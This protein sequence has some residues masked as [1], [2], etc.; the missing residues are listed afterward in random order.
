MAYEVPKK[1][2]SQVHLWELRQLW[3]NAAKEVMDQFLADGKVA[4]EPGTWQKER[5]TSY[6]IKKKL[7]RMVTV[8][9]GQ[10]T[11]VALEGPPFD[12]F[13]ELA[14]QKAVL[15]NAIPQE[16]GDGYERMLEQKSLIGEDG[17]ELESH[18][19][20]EE[21]MNPDV[22]EK[23]N[24]KSFK[25]Y[26]FAL[27]AAIHAYFP[28]ESWAK[29]MELLKN[30]YVT[31]LHEKRRW[32][33]MTKT[34]AAPAPGGRTY[35]VEITPIN[36][37]YHAKFQQ[38]GARGFSSMGPRLTVDMPEKH[39]QERATN[40]WH[41]RFVEDGPG[42]ETLIEFFRSGTIS[43]PF[44]DLP[45][46][47]RKVLA[48]AKAKEVLTAILIRHLAVHGRGGEAPIPIDFVGVNLQTGVK[49]QKLKEKMPF[50]IGTF[51][52]SAAERQSIREHMAAL[53]TFHDKDTDFDIAGDTVTAH[54]RIVAFNFGVNAAI[55][56]KKLPK[57][58]PLG[59]EQD[60]TNANALG[61]F[62]AIHDEF[63]RRVEQHRDAYQEGSD[64]RRLVERHLALA[65]SLWREIEGHM[66]GMSYKTPARIV[67]LAWLMGC[68]PH[69]N[70]KS[71]KD[72]T[73]VLAVESHFVA[74][75]IHEMQLRD[76][77]WAAPMW[78]NVFENEDSRDALMH[79][80]LVFETGNYE[81]QRL[82][83]G[84]PG[85]KIV[86]K[87]FAE[88]PLANR[89]AG[90]LKA[91]IG[92]CRQVEVKPNYEGDGFPKGMTERE[93]LDLA[94]RITGWKPPTT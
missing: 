91:A 93:F 65:R 67:N 70:C 27:A 64:E 45:A 40:F 51:F 87:E 59:I 81:I 39:E 36:A 2:I 82:N 71:G 5:S 9:T 26:G 47:R 79:R 57:E 22:F 89:F 76:L 38:Y 18:R 66:D 86:P 90:Y 6:H 83:T 41:D 20:V 53:E 14:P 15:D 74:W 25:L 68:W 24:S 37:T 1:G 29:I 8:V 69:F 72:R 52:A 61:R 11:I 58:Q 77:V 17:A 88:R 94:A 21:A 50:G 7:G 19:G 55:L 60:E 49:Q 31:N 30:R 23:Y 84:V 13:H 42:G 10:P 34:V 92:L 48:E 78:R 54:F 33:R 63:V 85:Y 16:G 35:R 4:Q 80:K 44:D 75:Q 12:E 32:V 62:H 28:D 56:A 3:L 43:Y 46:A 73:S